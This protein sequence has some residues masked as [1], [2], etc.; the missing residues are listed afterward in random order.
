MATKQ[1]IATYTF[2]T[3][4]GEESRYPTA[5][6]ERLRIALEN[7]DQP[8]IIVEAEVAKVGADVQ[9]ACVA[10]TLK[11]RMQDAFAKHETPQDAAEMAEAMR[12]RMYENEWLARGEAAGPRTSL[13]YE[14]VCAA[15]AEA[16][17]DVNEDHVRAMIKGKEG[18]KNTLANPVVNA[19]YERIKSEK[20]LAKAK[21]A[22]AAA[23]DAKSDLVAFTF[24][25]PA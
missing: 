3:A 2:L 17:M 23:K 4:A 25:P 18:R 5:E 24:T 8:R 7:G 12:D 20:A 10:Y 1:K 15:L 9:K 14:A 21:A 11:K 16:K 13:L 6:T 22:K 19:H